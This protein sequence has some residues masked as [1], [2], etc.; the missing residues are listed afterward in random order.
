MND[1]KRWCMMLEEHASWSR[2]TSDKYSS[3]FIEEFDSFV[4]FLFKHG[5][6]AEDDAIESVRKSN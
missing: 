3:H 4:Y 1:N 2:T 6:Q 5:T